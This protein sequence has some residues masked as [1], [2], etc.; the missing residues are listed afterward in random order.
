MLIYSEVMLDLDTLSEVSHLTSES[1]RVKSVGVWC[2]FAY[3]LL[4]FYH[5]VWTLSNFSN[6]PTL[7]KSHYVNQ[8]LKVWNAKCQLL[9]LLSSKFNFPANVGFTS[10]P[11]Y[12]I[13]VC[14]DE[15]GW[16]KEMVFV[17]VK[18]IE[19]WC[20]SVKKVCWTSLSKAT[21]PTEK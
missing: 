15:P 17:G 4:V 20:Y 13:S 10:H 6:Q 21:L 11:N 19:R 1:W 5:R 2:V 12:F 16:P 9:H 14:L 18:G 8:T 7:L 3:T